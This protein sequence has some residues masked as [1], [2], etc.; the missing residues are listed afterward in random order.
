V[1]LAAPLRAGRVGTGWM[2]LEVQQHC[3]WAKKVNELTSVNAI[4]KPRG[5]NASST[6]GASARRKRLIKDVMFPR[7]TAADEARLAAPMMV[8]DYSEQIIGLFLHV[9]R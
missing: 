8:A 6:F 1:L 2:P 9:L 5:T 3:W 4:A 7:C